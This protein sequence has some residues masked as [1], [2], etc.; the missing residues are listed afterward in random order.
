MAINPFR[1]GTTVD[2]PYF[3]GRKKQLQQIMLPLRNSTSLIIYSPRH[4]GKSSLAVKVLKELEAE[5]HPTIYID[6][7]KVSSREKFIEL[8]AAEVLRTMTN[9]EK[10]L[11]TSQGMYGGLEQPKQAVGSQQ[12]QETPQDMVLLQLLDLVRGMQPVLGLDADGELEMQF[13]IDPMQVAQALEDILSLPSRWMKTPAEITGIPSRWTKTPSKMTGATSRWAG[14]HT[15]M[16]D[17]TSPWAKAPAEMTGMTSPWM[18]APVEMNSI[19]SPRAKA[20]A[21]MMGIPSW[22]NNMKCW[23]VVFDEFL[24][25]EKPG[26]IALENELRTC[27]QNQKNVSYL[28]LGN[29]LEQIK[30][31]ILHK[32]GAF[33]HFS[34]IMH[35]GKI[36]EEE[37]KAFL[38]ERFRAGELIVSPEPG[39]SSLSSVPARSSL[40]VKSGDVSISP[41][42]RRGSISPELLDQIIEYSRNSPYYVQYMGSVIWELAQYP[43]QNPCDADPMAN[44]R[45]HSIDEAV[46]SAIERL[47]V[48]DVAVA[49]AIERILINQSP[50]FR[51]IRS[52]LT[53]LQAK[54]L[55]AVALH[56]SGS[57][58][59]GFLQKY[60]LSPTSSIQRGYL[61]LTELG[62]LE[63]QANR[64]YFADPFFERWLK[65]EN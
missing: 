63:K 35:L 36:P 22:W 28:L 49:E 40:T 17:M 59:S 31:L 7:L 4:T 1:Y 19:T 56:G 57:Y 32:E 8:Y 5:G 61:R 37:S 18:K 58:D 64:F 14:A 25:M 54:L 38:A 52:Q 42:P 13:A 39:R 9:L 41:D 44:K 27:F 26:G 65:W 29:H 3:Y 50:Y 15:E 34:K 16:T 45:L 30:T 2:G 21:E 46:P 62:I 23:I 47:P 10:Q 53:A 6:F 24:E 20:P 55:S 48:V 51:G 11:K 12:G 60:R 33:Y 43:H